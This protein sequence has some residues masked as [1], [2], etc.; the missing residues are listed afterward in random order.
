MIFDAQ[1]DKK[2]QEK[3]DLLCVVAYSAHK[4]TLQA[5]RNVLEKEGI[6][7]FRLYEYFTDPPVCKNGKPE[8]GVVHAPF[9]RRIAEI[10][11]ETV[12][13]I[14]EVVATCNRGDISQEQKFNLLVPKSSGHLK[15]YFR[16][17]VHTRFTQQAAESGH[18]LFRLWEKGEGIPSK[19]KICTQKEL[20]DRPS[21]IVTSTS[22]EKEDK[23][24]I[25]LEY[26]LCDH[27]YAYAKL[28]ELDLVGVPIASSE[29]FYGYFICGIPIYEEWQKKDETLKQVRNVLEE[30]AKQ[31]FLPVLIL[32]ENHWEE[33]VLSE[34]SAETEGNKIV[35]GDYKIP[36]VFLHTKSSKTPLET[37]LHDL[38]R[39]RQSAWESDLDWVKRSL[40]FKKFLVASEKMIDIMQKQVMR[41]KPKKAAGGE[42]LPTVLIIGGAGSGK[43]TIAKMIPLFSK[44]YRR[45]RV[46]PINLAS[47]KP[48]EIAPSLLMGLE[49][50]IPRKRKE[51]ANK[52]KHLSVSLEG[53]FQKIVEIELE[54]QR[55]E[56]AK[57]EKVISPVIIL[58]ELNSLDI[59]TQGSLLNL[60]EN[61]ELIPV[62]GAKA[63][64]DKVKLGCLLIG[65]MN[66]DPERLT[67]ESVLRG[68][69]KEDKGG[70]FGGVI[71]EILYE[72]FRK[73]RRL[74]EDLYYRFI[75]GGKIVLPPL[76]ERKEDIPILFYLFCNHELESE[77]EDSQKRLY[78]PFQILDAVSELNWPGNVRHLQTFAPI[79]MRYV[80]KDREIVKVDMSHICRAL[81]E[82]GM[83]RPSVCK[84]LQDKKDE[85]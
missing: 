47:L 25:L 48:P 40:L 34:E 50:G 28:K 17:S 2:R 41:L 78:I 19:P 66:E 46:Y 76:A 13:N 77:N 39:E 60:L 37:R 18:K 63:K 43:D 27:I 30:N 52:E 29:V 44:T 11:S 14:S 80:N 22:I 24:A 55:E 83:E 70:S 85:E 15:D 4:R 23:P 62:G 51:N 57:E 67:K 53:I 79:V 6:L 1:S 72:H 45:K 84:L 54:K 81:K 3:S 69:T 73:I 59:D 68:L 32:F 71:G 42:K 21:K 35:L 8:R 26:L 64:D 82:M 65:E 12:P 74:R 58:D 36:M 56:K 5:V 9:L 20:R 33:K 10:E 31:Y 7:N 75:R 49:M 61:G 16:R 38:W